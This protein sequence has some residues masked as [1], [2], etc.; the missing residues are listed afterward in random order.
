MGKTRGVLSLYHCS[1]GRSQSHKGWA[2]SHYLMGYV[3]TQTIFIAIQSADIYTTGASLDIAHFAAHLLMGS[4][5][6]DDS[7]YSLAS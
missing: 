6:V 5:V 1:R 2:K 7:A 3:P 4:F